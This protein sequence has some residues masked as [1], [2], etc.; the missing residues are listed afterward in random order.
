MKVLFVAIHVV[1]PLFASGFLKSFSSIRIPTPPLQA[2]SSNTEEPT[3]NR[4]P[5]MDEKL[6]SF[7]QIN[8]DQR[9]R[10]EFETFV[11][12]HVKEEKLFDPSWSQDTSPFVELLNARLAILGQSV[13]DNSWDTYITS[14]FDKSTVGPQLWACVDMLIQ[15]KTVVRKSEKSCAKKCPRCSR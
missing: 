7:S 14:G 2:S 4:F 8:D 5:F 3:V 15:L 1:L 11:L 9:R 13:Q 6:N 12:R 10:T